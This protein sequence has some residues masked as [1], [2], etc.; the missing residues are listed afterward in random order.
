VSESR[1]DSSFVFLPSLLSAISCIDE[2]SSLIVMDIKD[3]K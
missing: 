2:P 1:S 3:Y